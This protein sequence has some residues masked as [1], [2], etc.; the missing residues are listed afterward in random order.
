MQ[1]QTR[2]RTLTWS[3]LTE[4]YLAVTGLPG[5]VLAICT[6]TPTAPTG[7]WTSLQ[8]RGGLSVGDW[9]VSRE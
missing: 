4:E 5:D 1:V 6:R 9:E 8:G 2:S 7:T 3:L